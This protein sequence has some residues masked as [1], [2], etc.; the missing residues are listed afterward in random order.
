MTLKTFTGVGITELN[1][2]A[3]VRFSNDIIH[4]IKK[5]AKLNAPRMDFIDLPHAM[6]KIDALKFMQTHPQFQS[7]EDQATIEEILFTKETVGRR[8][9][10]RAR[11]KM[12]PSL[13]SI[14][15]RT[16]KDISVDD[17]LMAINV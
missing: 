12:M 3:K 13:D 7:P 14:M 5:Y 6:S 8:D 15:K 4:H 17:V 2:N 16:R 9:E 1:E 10:T 11:K